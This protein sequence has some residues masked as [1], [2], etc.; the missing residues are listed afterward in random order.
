MKNCLLILVA[1]MFAFTVCGQSLAAEK[2][3]CLKSSACACGKAGCLVDG[4]C[5]CGD[6]CCKSCSCGCAQQK[7]EQG[8]NCH[9]K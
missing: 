4:K 7:A 2:A 9:K 8:C 1:V 6:N 3:C 5:T